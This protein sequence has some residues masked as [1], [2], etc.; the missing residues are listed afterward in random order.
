MKFDQI[1]DILVNYQKPLLL[2]ALLI[3]A[4]GLFLFFNWKFSILIILSFI[5]LNTSILFL[6]GIFFWKW[7]LANSI[8]I[9]YIII[10]KPEFDYKQGLLT[11]LTCFFLAPNLN[12]FPNLSW[13]ATPYNLFYDLKWWMFMIMNIDNE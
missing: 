8:F 9:I 3:E 2:I 7:I 4:L 10:K 6:S 12:M 11:I 13:Y 1:K 5:G